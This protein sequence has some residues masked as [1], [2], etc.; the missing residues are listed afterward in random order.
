MALRSRS[1]ARSAAGGGA[2]RTSARML[3]RSRSWRHLLIRARYQPR[4]CAGQL[5]LAGGAVV[6]ITAI[7]RAG[8]LIQGYRHFSSRSRRT[9]A[10][11]GFLHLSH[12]LRW[13]AAVRR[14]DPLRHDALQPHAADVLE[15][16]G[17][18]TRQMLDKP[19][20]SPLGLA[21]QL[22]EPPLALD[23]RQVAQ[24]DAIVLDQVEG[25]QHRLMTPALA[26]AARG[27]P[28]SRPHWRSPPRRRS[29]TMPP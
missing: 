12:D 1:A 24:V 10:L 28:A 14:I 11:S 26:S 19:D 15:D 13:S 17:A 6:S 5:P 4:V 22:L 7:N 9:A 23:Q 8:R 29:G 21:E 18:V 3:A 16:G 2:T 27:S 25:V 20:G